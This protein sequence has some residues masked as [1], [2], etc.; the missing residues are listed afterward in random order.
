[1]DYVSIYEQNKELIDKMSTNIDKLS[2]KSKKYR[3]T[4]KTG[5]NNTSGWGFLGAFMFFFLISVVRIVKGASY[6]KFWLFLSAIALIWSIYYIINCRALSALEKENAE[7]AA[8]LSSAFEGTVAE[9]LMT[10]DALGKMYEYFKAG[11][12]TTTEEAV[13]MYNQEGKEAEIQH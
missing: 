6:S 2:K 13:N 10:P 3:D 1:M 11:K 12:V 9:E 4:G 5:V 7:I 8:K